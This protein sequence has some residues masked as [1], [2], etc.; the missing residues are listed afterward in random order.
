MPREDRYALSS[1]REDRTNPA[2]FALPDEIG[3][4]GAVL[5]AAE[6]LALVY[7]DGRALFQVGQ[8]LSPFHIFDALSDIVCQRLGTVVSVQKSQPV[9]QR[10]KFA[11]PFVY[12]MRTPP[13]EP[14]QTVAA[15]GRHHGTAYIPFEIFRLRPLVGDSE[16]LHPHFSSGIGRIC[17]GQLDVE[18]L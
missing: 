16:L 17:V 12:V 2:V 7:D 11:Q 14:P 13:G 6:R 1:A 5:P 15:G 18:R 9:F 10:L 3:V 4:R 8:L